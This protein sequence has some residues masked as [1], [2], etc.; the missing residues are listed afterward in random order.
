MNA[1]KG[2]LLYA[3]LSPIIYASLAG[4]AKLNLIDDET[5]HKHSFRVFMICLSVFFIVWMTNISCKP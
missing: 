4:R 3:M 2:L 1:E 5:W